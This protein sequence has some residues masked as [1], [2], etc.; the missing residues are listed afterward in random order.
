MWWNKKYN[1]CLQSVVKWKD[2]VILNYDTIHFHFIFTP[3]VLTVPNI[4]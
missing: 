4:Q 2:K 1:I 3:K